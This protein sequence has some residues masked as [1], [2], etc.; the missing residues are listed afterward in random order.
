[1]EPDHLL[2]GW[3]RGSRFGA[4]TKGFRHHMRMVLYGSKMMLIGISNGQTLKL[5]TAIFFP[6]NYIELGHFKPKLFLFRCNTYIIMHV[7]WS[8][9]NMFARKKAAYDIGIS[10]AHCCRGGTWLFPDTT[11]MC[12]VVCWKYYRNPDMT[13]VRRLC[14][15]TTCSSTQKRPIILMVLL[16]LFFFGPAIWEQTCFD[17]GQRG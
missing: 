15:F 2:L 3:G 9:K 6:P 1:V 13:P 16:A 10:L 12:C 17:I 5:C 11:K 4:N 8:N 7:F 14:V